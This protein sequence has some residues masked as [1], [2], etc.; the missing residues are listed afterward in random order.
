MTARRNDTVCVH[1]NPGL[2][3]LV[4]PDDF[5]ARAASAAGVGHFID[6]STAF[7][8]TPGGGLGVSFRM[9]APTGESWMQILGPDQARALRDAIDEML[10]VIAN[11]AREAIDERRTR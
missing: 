10:D 9:R 7:R 1:M 8:V 3:E 4:A 5:L 11:E 6:V 2:A